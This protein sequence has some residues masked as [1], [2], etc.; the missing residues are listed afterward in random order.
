MQRALKPIFKPLLGVCFILL[1]AAFP[2]AVLANPAPSQFCRSVQLGENARRWTM[3][4]VPV[5]LVSSLPNVTKELEVLRQKGDADRTA[6]SLDI[7]STLVASQAQTVT[8]AQHGSFN[9][10][11]DQM[12]VLTRSLP[13]RFNLLKVKTWTEVG[14]AYQR[15]AKIDKSREV[16]QLAIPSVNQIPDVRTR[17]AAQLRLAEGLVKYQDPSTEAMLKNAFAI[18]LT[19]QDAYNRNQS[20]EQLIKLNLQANQ[21]ARALE[22]MQKLPKESDR[23]TFTIQ[24]AA[25]YAKRKDQ[26]SAKKLLDPL[27]KQA[28]AT[29]DVDQRET[30]L[31]N[32]II[33]Y[34]PSG[35]LQRSRSLVLEMKRPNSFRAR[36]WFT[37]AGEARYFNQPELRKQAIANLI[38]D[39]K[40]ANMRDQFGSRFD[41]A[42]YGEMSLSANQRD[43]QPELKTFIAEFRPVNVLIIAIRDLISQKQY[44]AARNLVPRP[45]MVQIDAGYFD[46]TDETLDEIALAELRDRKTKS[47]TD[48]IAN[49]KSNI[50][51]LIKFAQAFHQAG[52]SSSTDKLFD[53]AQTIVGQGTEL[54]SQALLANALVLTKQPSDRALER[55]FKQIETEKESAKR[56]ELLLSI[57]RYFLESRSTY[58]ALAERLNLMQQVDFATTEG[59]QSLQLAKAEDA[60]RFIGSA[61]KTASEKFNFVLG[62]ADL[63]LK[64]GKPG[65]ARS[66]LDMPIQTLLDAPESAK[67]PSNER[68][69]YFKQIAERLA[70]AGDRQSALTIAQ[71]ISPAKDRDTLKKKL[72]CY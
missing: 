23:T 33:H 70:R 43:Y 49:E 9:V 1:H 36:S 12:A 63:Y 41:Q 14:I 16:L 65:T 2:L 28:L 71:Y 5:S 13:N 19:I 44:D 38:K 61:G 48:R 6:N 30:Q 57:S 56:A 29:K 51:R 37:I 31:M 15:I 60:Y 53:R 69:G 39:A 10:V 62:L 50:P 46:L 18:S 67:L 27:V 34:S 42:W 32:I 45:M 8:P 64:Q 54:S 68:S 26:A 66:L 3:E 40:A 20:L 52:D 58:F 24:I 21:P 59:F 17:L 7:L 22:V 72:Q 55:I 25:S 11:L 35:D 47:A 4:I